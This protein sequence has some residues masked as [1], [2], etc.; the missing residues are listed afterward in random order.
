MGVLEGKVA[1]VTGAARGQG[2]SHARRLAEEGADIIAIDLCAQPETVTVPGATPEDLEETVR[3][4]EEYDRRIIASV[5]DIR[6]LRTLS[7]TVR[8]GVAELGHLDIV[9][10]NA[11]IWAVGAD[12]PEDRETREKVWKETVDINLTGQWNV[13]EATVPILL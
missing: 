1:F 8:A 4:V 7:E 2:R 3:L 6:D 5:A 9:V 11:A 13:L 10:G 12:E